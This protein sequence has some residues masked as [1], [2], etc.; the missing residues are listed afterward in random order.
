MY[1]PPFASDL[2]RARRHGRDLVDET[3]AANERSILSSEIVL[4]WHRGST[5]GLIILQGSC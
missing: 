1:S 5:A 3:T 4:C 2:S